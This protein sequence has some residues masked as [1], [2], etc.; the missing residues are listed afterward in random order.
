MP[1]P[2]EE[3]QVAV[4][5]LARFARR[6]YRRAVTPEEVARLANFVDAT[7]REKGT[8]L[9]GIQLAMQAALCSPHFL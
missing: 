3:H 5:I 1:Q 6:A 8:F 7:L 4:E 9:E 2:G